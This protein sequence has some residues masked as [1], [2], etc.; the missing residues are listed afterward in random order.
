VKGFKGLNL[1][2]GSLLSLHP[3]SLL[4]D[5]VAVLAVAGVLFVVVGR[6]LHRRTSGKHVATWGVF[7]VTG[8]M[9]GGKTYKLTSLALK[10]LREGRPVY[11]NY[12]VVGAELVSSWSDVLA[13]PDDALVVLAELQLWW[14]AGPSYGP[15]GVEEWI[16]QL[17]H[18]RRTLVWDSQHWTFVNTRVRKLTR[19]VWEGRA[20]LRGHEYTYF[21]GF[22][23]VPGRSASNR[24]GRERVRRSRAVM[25]A[26]RTED[27]V[28]A[29]LDWLSSRGRRA[30]AYS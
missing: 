2:T 19:G 30:S 15:P 16:S 12:P 26:Y 3:G 18:H 29:D 20:R 8:G 9:G 10:A 6:S 21:D 14:P 5:V 1:H 17:R 25:D 27:D 28:A 13:A 7:G 24:L 23:Y 22:G 4:F 11:S